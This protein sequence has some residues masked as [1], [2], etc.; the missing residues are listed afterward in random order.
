M[1]LNSLEEPLCPSFPEQSSCARSQACSGN[2]VVSAQG[3][4]QGPLRSAV[5]EVPGPPRTPIPLMSLALTNT[6]WPLAIRHGQEVLRSPVT[7]PF[8][9]HEGAG[10][11]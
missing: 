9:V 7:L 4:E 5:E 6:P 10:V 1:V 8:G 3:R 11:E 2:A